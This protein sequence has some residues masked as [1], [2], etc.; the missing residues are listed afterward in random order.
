VKVSLFWRTFLLIALLLSMSLGIG[1]FLVRK[2]DPT[3]PEQNLAWELA[4]VV[5]LT[6][7]A[8]I[9]AQPSKRREL[10]SI[11][12]KE[13]GVRILPLEDTD[14]IQQTLPVDSKSKIEDAVHRLLGPDTVLA[15]RVND[16]AGLW[17]SFNIDG[18]GY[19]LILPKQRL[20]R[21]TELPLLPVF[22][23]LTLF[24]LAGTYIMSRLVNKPLSNLAHALSDLGLGKTPKPLRE[25]LASEIASVN[26]RFN[27]M[28]RDLGQLEADRTLA[29]AGISHDIRTPLTRLRMEV[30]LAQLSDA[31]RQGMIEDI[32]RINEIVAQFMDYARAARSTHQER[33]SVTEKLLNVA[34]RF[35]QSNPCLASSSS[36]PVDASGQEISLPHQ[37]I[38]NVKIAPDLY[39]TGNNTDLERMVGNLL[40]NARRYGKTVGSSTAHIYLRA[41]EQARNGKEP[42]QLKITVA[43]QG[44]GVPPEKLES[45]KRPFMRLDEARGVQ[46]GAGLGLAIV[47]RIAQRHDGQLSL[48]LGSLHAAGASVPSN[49]LPR[50]LIAEL[51]F[52]LAN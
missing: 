29:L 39:W 23:V 17:V 31:Q 37:T 41:W 5:N 40:E 52:P 35:Q 26:R 7:N 16:Y 9:A 25:D 19:W 21:Q 36:G 12:E 34:A 49:N 42:A 4:S 1:L 48:S 44:Q 50:G 38:L 10:L 15:T 18:D 45:L 33:V 6:R 11:L 47:E 51:S 24:A 20:D 3:P 30:E 43:D 46:E 8:L 28:T 14:R 2:L 27:Q 22:S 32:E 13:E